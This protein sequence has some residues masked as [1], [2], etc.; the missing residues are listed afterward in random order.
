MTAGLHLEGIRKSFGRTPVL[1]DVTIDAPTGRITALIGQNGAGKT[2]LF[3]ILMGLVGADA[4]RATLGGVD[5]L[6]LPTGRKGAAGLGYL[7]Q[8]NGSFPELTVARNIT[9]ML[10]LHPLDRKERRE[11]L[12]ELLALVGIGHL[13]DR[14]CRHLSAGERRRLELAKAFIPRPR[15]LLL[16]EPFSGLDPCI[17]EEIVA[18]LRSLAAGGTGILVTDH[19]AHTMVRVGDF[20]Y[21]LA[22]GR[23]VSQ[24]VPGEMLDGEEARKIY[25]GREFGPTP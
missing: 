5:I 14:L 21:L 1:R 24:G 4:G 16:D 11:R 12:D 23:I 9:A 15:I 22:E 20:A 19:N 6:R 7:P 2:T 3:K 18:I 8:E 17:V 13:A 25:F 10:E